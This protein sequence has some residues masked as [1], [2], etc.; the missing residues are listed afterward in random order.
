MKVADVDR[1]IGRIVESKL[2]SFCSRRIVCA[3]KGLVWIALK[4]TELEFLLSL[5]MIFENIPTTILSQIF[6]QKHQ[7][8]W[9]GID[10]TEPFR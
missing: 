10:R 6:Q 3:R 9:S 7:I 4:L 1:T 5:G 2:I 8:W